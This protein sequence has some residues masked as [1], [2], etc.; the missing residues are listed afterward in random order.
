MGGAAGR[1]GET[2]VRSP[3]RLIFWDFNGTLL[4]DLAYAIDVRNRTFP[5]F[6]LP[7]IDSVEQYHEQFTFPVRD[8]YKRARVTEESF[9]EVANAWMAEYVRGC[10]GVPLHCDVCETL[11]AFAQAGLE[12]VILSVSDMGVLESQ[13]ADY[14]IRPYFRAVL[15]LSHIYAT[16][17]VEIGLAYLRQCGLMPQDCVLLGD[18][19]HDAEVA[20]A[21]GI[22]CILISR[23]HQ[24]VQTLQTSGLPVCSTLRDAAVLVLS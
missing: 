19:L 2:P 9:T 12:Q 24:N 16:S 17:K 8:Y 14:P 10:K 7:G 21:M 15:G 4:D 5:L 1:T 23:G 22:D 18:T 6:G 3:Y 11:E 13:L 20:H